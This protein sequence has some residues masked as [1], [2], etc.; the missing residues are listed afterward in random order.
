M[1]N[2]TIALATVAS[3]IGFVL[4]ALAG[5]RYYGDQMTASR[6]SAAQL[7]EQKAL[8]DQ[9]ATE[10][11]GLRAGKNIDQ[12]A[13]ESLRKSVASLD[14]QLSTQ[15]E[16]LML[17][18]KLLK[19]DNIDEG[20]HI[21]NVGIKPT[22]EPLLFAYSFVIRQQAARLKTVSVGYSMQVNGQQGDEAI[23]YSLAE[24]DEQQ[25]SATAK[26][27]L[28]YFSVI[29]GIIKL[30]EHF[31]PQNLLISAWPEKLPARRRE[32]TFDWPEAGGVGDA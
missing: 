26:T 9:Q 28:K 18:G 30:P 17:Y 15:E 27:K 24:L 25:A 7:L 13:L 8:I 29:E 10:L 32:L 11:I 23:S 4:G 2:K 1:N 16:E 19:V 12:Q 5:S 31:V 6:D 20:L 22:G 21:L 14:A 3:L